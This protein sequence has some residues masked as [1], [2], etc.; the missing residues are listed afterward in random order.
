MMPGPLVDHRIVQQR[1]GTR[2]G[3]V[4]L[5][6]FAIH[7]SSGHA[8]H[9][10]PHSSMLLMGAQEEVQDLFL[11]IHRVLCRLLWSLLASP[12]C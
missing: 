6:T 12:M 1:G 3:L 10:N 4:W 11:S 9:H 2:L 7:A 5:P 8:S